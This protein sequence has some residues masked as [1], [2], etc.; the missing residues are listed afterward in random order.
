MILKGLREKSNQKHIN[1]LLNTRET[2][3]NDAKIES[4]GVILNSNEF[5]DFEA[6][7]DFSKELGIHPNKIKIIAYTEDADLVS[8]SRELLFSKKEIGWNAK[9]KNNELADFISKKFDALLCFYNEEIIEINVVTALSKASFK[10]G[11]SGHDER[12]FDLILDIK[13]KKIELF[14]EELKKYLNILNKLK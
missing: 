5:D 2:S 4:L 14:K 3:L 1:K 8:S 7:R 12:F 6:I 10:I 13:T 9:I 11:L